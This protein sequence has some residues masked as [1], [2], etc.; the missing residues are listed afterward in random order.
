MIKFEHN[1]F[2]YLVEKHATKGMMVQTFQDGILKSNHLLSDEL[3]KGKKTCVCWGWR[4][5]Q[6]A[7]R[8]CGKGKVLLSTHIKASRG[9]KH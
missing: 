7:L 4:K 3:F 5:L 6:V 9:K 1:G 2:K 8:C